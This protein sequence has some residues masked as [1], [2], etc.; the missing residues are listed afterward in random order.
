MPAKG[1]MTPDDTPDP[2]ATRAAMAAIPDSGPE[3]IQPGDEIVEEPTDD[4]S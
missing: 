1:Y 3:L 4:A 2:E